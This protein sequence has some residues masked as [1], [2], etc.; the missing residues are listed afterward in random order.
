[1]DAID[2]HGCTAA[3]VDGSGLPDLYCTVG[4]KRGSGLKSNELWLDPGGPSPVEVAASAV[5]PIPRAAA[6]WRP[7]STPAD[8]RP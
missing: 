7:C 4:G 8:R 5:W 6:G 3:D 2:R 1:M